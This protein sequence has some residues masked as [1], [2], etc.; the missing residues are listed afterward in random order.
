MTLVVPLA[1]LAAQVVAGEISRTQQRKAGK[2]RDKAI[3]RE[4]RKNAI[5]RAL[6]APTG[7]ARQL[8]SGRADTS[9][10]DTIGG[11]AGVGS[12]LA[13]RS[14]TNK[15]VTGQTNLGAPTSALLRANRQGVA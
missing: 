4:N 9:I 2:K 15:P 8:P 3:Q 14:A 12:L 6:G 7:T 5:A 11:I 13:F 10:I 1:L